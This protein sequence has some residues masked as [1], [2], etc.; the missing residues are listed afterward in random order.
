M[1]ATNSITSA[2][3]RPNGCEPDRALQYD[4]EPGNF[5]SASPRA[6][7]I[8]ENTL[9][10]TQ[11]SNAALIPTRCRRCRRLDTGA[12]SVRTTRFTWRSPAPSRVASVRPRA[13]TCICVELIYF[14]AGASATHTCFEHTAIANYDAFANNL[15]YHAG[16]N[17]RWSAAYS[18]LAAAQVA[19]FDVAGLS[20]DPQFVA[21]PA[22][23]NNWDDQLNVTSPAANAGH[24]H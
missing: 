7:A 4:R 21:L 18:N 15:C 22:A 23:G 9:A 8:A 12:S 6:G 17:G 20:S 19:G 16:S 24:T 2:Y 11:T 1:A 10:N 13:A 14:G 5:S 3:A